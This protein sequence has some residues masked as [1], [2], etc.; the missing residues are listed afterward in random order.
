MT[1][2]AGCVT[3]QQVYAE[4]LYGS[5]A[6][7]PSDAWGTDLGLPL[8]YTR[9]GPLYIQRFERGIAV[10]N[11]G[12]EPVWLVLG[13]HFVDLEGRPCESVL[14]AGHSADVFSCEGRSPALPAPRER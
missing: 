8:H 1:A 4:F 13:G 3:R 10:A 7:A 2:V 14:L 6:P 9:E 5:G 11:V 12:V